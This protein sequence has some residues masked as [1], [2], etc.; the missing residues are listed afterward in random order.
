MCT[1]FCFSYGEGETENLKAG[2]KVLAWIMVLV[3]FSR[4]SVKE[5]QGEDVTMRI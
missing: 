1:D 2:K 3:I 4:S 5:L